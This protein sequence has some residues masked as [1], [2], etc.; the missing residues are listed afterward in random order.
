[1]KHLL[2]SAEAILILAF[3]VAF[4]T[5]LLSKYLSHGVGDE[6]PKLETVIFIKNA[7]DEIEGIVKSIYSWRGAPLEL[8]IVDCG[9]SDQTHAILERLSR[10]YLGLRLLLLPDSPFDL[11]AQEALKHTSS[12]ALLLL[13]GKTLSSREMIKSVDLVLKKLSE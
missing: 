8:L 12:P 11:C 6:L 5:Y 9:S 1:V 13:D 10:Q 4:V 7:Q 3:I 2:L